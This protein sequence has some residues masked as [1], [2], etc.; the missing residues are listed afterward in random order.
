MLINTDKY[1]LVGG[2]AAS[3]NE[4]VS[5]NLTKCVDGKS[6]R[7]GFFVPSSDG[8]KFIDRLVRNK[9]VSSH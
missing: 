7:W 1:G 6:M 4:L 9:Q 5:A 3:M 2:L 8:L